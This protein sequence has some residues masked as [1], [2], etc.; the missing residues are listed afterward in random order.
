M[1]FGLLNSRFYVDLESCSRPAGTLREESER[2]A[3]DL[4]NISDNLILGLSSGLDSQIVLHSFCSQGLKINCAFLYLPGYNEFELNN[5]KILEKKYNIT[6]QIVELNPDAIREEILATATELNIPPNQII[7]RKFLSML[8]DSAD[9][10]QGLEGPNFAKSGNNF[11]FFETYNSF[12]KSRLRAFDSLNRT[13]SVISWEQTPEML[14]SILD[15][16]IVKSFLQSYD[17]TAKHNIQYTDGTEIDFKDRWD[18]F[19]KHIL[20]ATHWGKELEY[21]P[22]YQGPEGIDYVM[23]GPRCEYMKNCIFIPYELMLNHLTACNQKV[24]RLWENKIEG[25]GFL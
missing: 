1:N 7:Q 13:G 5:I 2:R 17:Y 20:Y 18:I 22:K 10:I 9:F 23:N 24:I 8:P 15:D 4:Y 12:E 21:F 19:I 11:Y 3:R 16:E 6:C 14:C 25:N